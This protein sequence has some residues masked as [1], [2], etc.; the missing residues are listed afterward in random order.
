MLRLVYLNI[1]YRTPISPSFRI[2]HSTNIVADVSPS[3]SS[4]AFPRLLIRWPSHIYRKRSIAV[5]QGCRA[6]GSSSAL[7]SSMKWLQSRVFLFLWPI[8]ISPTRASSRL[9]LRRPV[10]AGSRR[11]GKA[12][13]P[14]VEVFAIEKARPAD[15]SGVSFFASRSGFSSIS[16]A[17]CQGAKNGRILDRAR[18]ARRRTTARHSLHDDASASSI[19]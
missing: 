14:C 16:R 12:A 19:E 8:L 10:S 9:Y 3:E 1:L 18:K 4:W 11:F 6:H 5:S 7:T 2:Y 13:R 15:Q 17:Q